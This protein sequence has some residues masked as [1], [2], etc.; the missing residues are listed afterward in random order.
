MATDVDPL[1]ILLHL[2]LLAEDKVCFLPCLFFL[3]ILLL[4]FVLSES[5]S[6]CFLN[7]DSFYVVL[8]T[9]FRFTCPV[10]NIVFLFFLVLQILM[11]W[12]D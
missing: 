8:V 12:F 10:L 4:F 5:S 2:P 6:F 11:S 3:D 7:L 1:D 9:S